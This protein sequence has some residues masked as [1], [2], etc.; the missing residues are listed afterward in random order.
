[1]NIL[2]SRY[3]ILVNFILFFL[4]ISFITRTILLIEGG[5]KTDIG[6][7]S[8]FRVFG[9]GFVF[10]LSVALFFCAAYAVYLLVLPQRWNKSIA[11]RIITYISFFIVVLIIMFSF[12]A[13]FVFWNEFES[14][15]NFIAVDGT[16]NW[17]IW[18]HAAMRRRIRPVNCLSALSHA[19]ELALVR[20]H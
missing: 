11:N 16:A 14:R 20:L 13:E 17:D 19:G 2:R 5:S 10:D 8:L 6:L 18:P 9:K 7:L 3:S 4:I 15:F 12:F 1:M